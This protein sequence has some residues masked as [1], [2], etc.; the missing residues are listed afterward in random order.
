VIGNIVWYVGINAVIVF[1]HR[2]VLRG[3]QGDALL[4]PVDRA[5]VRYLLWSLVLALAIQIVLLL[6]LFVAATLLAGPGGTP[7]QLLGPAPTRLAIGILAALLLARVHLVFPAIAIG[8][9]SMTV[10]RSFRLTTGYT[11]PLVLG[12]LLTAV[13]LT[14]LGALV[15]TVLAAIGGAGSLTGVAIST[16][17]DFVQAAVV[18]SF[19]SRSYRFFISKPAARPPVAGLTPSA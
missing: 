15:Q 6:V 10:D 3:E 9:R 2:R 5:V 14:M 4:A 1:W 17:L 11:G 19:L 8:D 16:A 7:T 13:P 12:I 18:S